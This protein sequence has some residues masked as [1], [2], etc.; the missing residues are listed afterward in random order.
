MF[1]FDKN[2][3]NFHGS[4]WD[5]EYFQGSWGSSKVDLGL[6]KYSWIKQDQPGTLKISR[7]KEGSSKDRSLEM[8][9]P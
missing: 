5:L 6:R 9:R 7:I 3:E 1:Q 8:D 2:H 4:S